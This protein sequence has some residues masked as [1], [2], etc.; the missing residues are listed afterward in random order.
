MTIMEREISTIE[1]LPCIVDKFLSFL[2]HV[3]FR[4][5]NLEYQSLQKS[6][7]L[8]LDGYLRRQA[9]L[10]VQMN[11][12]FRELKLYFVGREKDPNFY[13]KVIRSAIT[14]LTFCAVRS[15]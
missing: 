11:V 7:A 1:Y 2:S 15:P 5:Y 6:L 9:P 10:K 12:S 8:V 3:S 4:Q 13:K 14:A